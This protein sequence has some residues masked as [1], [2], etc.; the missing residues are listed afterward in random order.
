MIE[1]GVIATG[2]FDVLDRTIDSIAELQYF[3]DCKSIP[4]REI[5]RE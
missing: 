2:A 1:Q 3:S 4:C 5:V